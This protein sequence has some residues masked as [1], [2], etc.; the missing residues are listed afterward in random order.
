MLSH[1]AHV[2]A[3]AWMNAAGMPE[4]GDV[5]WGSMG[6]LGITGVFEVKLFLKIPLDGE[7][8]GGICSRCGFLSR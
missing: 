1:F 5:G 4:I 7:L 6:S 3:L 2:P 8:G